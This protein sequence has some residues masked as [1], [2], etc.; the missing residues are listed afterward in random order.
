VG[1]ETTYDIGL[2][3]ADSASCFR[4]YVPNPRESPRAY[5]PYPKAGFEA[6]SDNSR[7]R[8]THYGVC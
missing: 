4:T 8:N 5:V 7:Q 3:E 1:P 2:L 6:E